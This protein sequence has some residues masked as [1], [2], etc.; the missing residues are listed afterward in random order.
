MEIVEMLKTRPLK[1]HKK[2]ITLGNATKD[3]RNSVGEYDCDP[4]PGCDSKTSNFFLYIYK[5]RKIHN[6][7]IF[8]FTP[9]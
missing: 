8:A 7:R 6:L 3:N 2:V 4:T 9:P 5:K 1:Y